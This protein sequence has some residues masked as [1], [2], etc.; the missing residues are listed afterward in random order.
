MGGKSINRHT[1]AELPDA[2]A[3]QLTVLQMMMMYSTRSTCVHSTE[4][5][6]PSGRHKDGVLYGT[7]CP[8]KDRI[9]L[10]LQIVER[11]QVFRGQAWVVKAYTGT[12]VQRH[13][14]DACST[15]LLGA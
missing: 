13:P 14:Q 11:R 10:S 5:T 4:L 7:V 2:P 15:P 3:Q 1:C 8:L 6:S 12:P 9:S